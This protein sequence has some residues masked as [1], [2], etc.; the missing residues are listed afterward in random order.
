[1]P[2]I[3]KEV[4]MQVGS[5]MNK[6]ILSLLSVFLFLSY[7]TGCAS[8][9]YRSTS[10][11]SHAYPGVYP[12]LRSGL[13]GLNEGKP[14]NLD[15]SDDPKAMLYVATFFAVI[16]VPLCFAIDTLCLPYDA[17]KNKEKIDTQPRA[18]PKTGSK[19]K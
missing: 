13:D 10:Y 7:L 19:K 12:G 6:K 1:M 4:G 11:E 18:E 9:N 5:I 16:D 15:M 2:G 14:F 8:I 17:F 3:K